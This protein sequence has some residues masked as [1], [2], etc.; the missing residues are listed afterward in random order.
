MTEKKLGKCSVNEGCLVIT[1]PR[2]C[3]DGQDMNDS[4]RVEGKI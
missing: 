2:Q 3:W 1:K 4:F